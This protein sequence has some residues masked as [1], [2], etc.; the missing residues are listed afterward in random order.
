MLF[1]AILVFIF[2]LSLLV[3]VHELGHFLVARRNGVKVLEFGFGYPP[4]FLGFYK[5]SK[6]KKW[7]SF[8]GK[9]NEKRD[10]IDGTIYTINYIPFGGF[11][12]M[13]GEEEDSDSKL[14]F[15]QKSPWV[16][17]K[18]IVA[19]V[20]FNFILAWLLLIMW[21]LLAPKTMPNQIIVMS[22][23][24][25]SPAALAGI[26]NN[27]FI[28]KAN[29]EKLENIVALQNFTK[30]HQGQEI[31]LTINHF[32]KNID[33][34]ITLPTDTDAPLGV[35]LAENGGNVAPDVIWWQTPYYAFMEI[36]GVIWLSISFIWGFVVSLFGGA[37]IATDSVSGPIG[38]FAFLYQIINFGPIFI[39]RFIAMLSIAIGFF[40]LIPFPALDGG[41]L[42]FI[43]L[44]GIKGKKI[45]KSEWENAI[46]W[47]GFILLMILFVVITYNDIN[48]WI[49]K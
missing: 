21:L 15:S 16:R 43:T 35:A 26:K 28:E 47:F 42:F 31:T 12:K 6:T 38:I 23:N 33:K 45:I 24:E 1:I 5:S 2:T 46:H 40:N 41:H 19:G 49:I 7:R 30:S 44:E 3:I 36:I 4:R 39:I 34:K 32:G 10:D 22:V 18:I 14:S 17:A 27:D 13:L 20:L 11:V 8:W 29:G 9:N 48:K 37:K 25:N